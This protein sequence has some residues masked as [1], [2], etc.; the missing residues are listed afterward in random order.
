MKPSL[1]GYDARGKPLFLEPEEATTHEHVIGSSGSGKSKYLEARMRGYLRNGQ[2]FALLDPHGT[3]YDDIVGFCAHYA[4]DRE[5]ILLN[6]SKPDQIVGF[7]PFSRAPV[8]DVSVQV[9]RRIAATMH[10]WGVRDTDQTPTLARTLRLVYTVML[11][12]NLGLPQI[13]HLIDFNAREIRSSLIEQLDSALVQK[14]WRELQMLKAKEWRDETLSAKNRLFKFLTSDVLCR[15]MGLP[16]RSINLRDV[17]DQGKVLLV[18]LAESD[19][20]SHENARAFGALLGNEFFEN[21][22][23]RERDESGRP[24]QPYFL[25]MDEFQA[26][27]SV[28]VANM[29]DQVRKFGLFLTLAHQRFGQLDENMPDAVLTNCRVKAVFG[30][31]P[32]QSAR[33]MAE[34][35]FIGDLDPKRIKAAIYQ[36]KFWPEYRRD[37]V[38]SHGTSQGNSNSHSNSTGGS[39]GSSVA[40]FGSTGTSLSFD[41]WFS[42]PQLTGERMENT[43]VGSSLSSS[44]SSSWSQGS[45]DSL[46]SSESESVADIPIFFPVPFREMSS[47]QFYS[48]EEQLTELTAALKEQF[49]RHCFIKIHGQKTQPLLVPFITPVSSFRDSREN[50]DWYVHWQLGRQG[51]LSPR[52]VDSLIEQQQTALLQLTAEKRCDPAEIALQPPQLS[53][54]AGIGAARSAKAGS[55]ERLTAQKSIWNRATSKTGG[56]A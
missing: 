1:L 10:A 37:K 11:E 12:Q 21:A 14:E 16:G 9:D 3:L 23:R 6:V 30:G 4:L 19:H 35:L 15:F 46:T 7:N 40:S 20:L 31:L 34:E 38:Y 51:A 55:S 39:Q 5:I 17:M 52:E 13:Q 2:G 49:P 8:G 24:P 22:L 42:F 44:N 33:L 41:D 45:T 54:V 27:M 32:A 29:L 43:S 53:V 26:F 36:T 48:T 50:L 56:P 25:L 18:N 28:D 47:I